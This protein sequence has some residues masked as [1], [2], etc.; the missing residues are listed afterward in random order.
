MRSSVQVSEAEI[1][2][3]YVKENSTR[4]VEFLR[5]SSAA[6]ADKVAADDAAITAWA[7]DH[8]AE[9][10]ERYDRDFDR[11]YNTSKQVSAQHIL[12]KFEEDDDEPT[13]ADIRG[14]MEAILAEATADG[15]DFG[16]LAKLHSEDSSAPRG[17]DLGKFDRKRMVEAFSDAAFALEPGQISGIVETQY[18][19]HVIKVNEVFEAKV[20][21]LAEV[22]TD[23]ARELYQEEQAPEQ[24]RAY[25]QKLVGV[26]DGSIEGEAADA[27]LAEQGLTV[28]ETGDFD[29]QA[30]T[31]PKLGRAPE[32][33]TAAFA[34]AQEGA[35]TKTPVELPTGFA[36]L[37]LKAASDADMA[38]YEEQKAA[39]RDR[40]LRTKQTRALEAWKAQL[41]ED[42]DIR[43][44]AGA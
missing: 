13:R 10:Q 29:L 43:I 4:N 3:A 38:K 17:G 28:Q 31:V 30:R 35:V 7:S 12:L 37:R 15:A 19:L 42:A 24:A 23:I 44:A 2:D 21:E 11:K 1:K 18:G 41:K 22:R 36:V 20:Q 34:L 6:F 26:L 40:L 25:A 9:V 32:V 16:E 14:R 33:A 8:D 5:V 27:L 39:I